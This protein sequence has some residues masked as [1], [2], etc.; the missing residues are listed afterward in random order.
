MTQRNSMQ[1]PLSHTQHHQQQHH[2]AA[3]SI[4]CKAASSNS[5]TPAAPGRGGGGGD[6]D[7]SAF[8]QSIQQQFDTRAP[9]YDSDTSY[10]APLAAALLDLLQLQ[11]GGPTWVLDLAAGTGLVGLAAAAAVGPQGRVVLV[12]VSAGMLAQAKAKYDAATAVG[13]EATTPAANAAAATSPAGI[14]A[15]KIIQGDIEDLQICL[16]PDWLGSFDAI[17]CSAATPFLRDPPAAL[18]AWRAWLKQPGGQLAFNTF[19]PPALEDFGTFRRLLAEAG[20]AE[21]PEPFEALGSVEAVTS[22]LK[23]AGYSHVQVCVC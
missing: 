5:N 12:D 20:V 6:S 11:P 22:A 2:S 15:V 7:T 3:H 1:H 19:V 8:L 16:Q 18:A 13:G 4:T 9:K 21:V 14:A 23:A 10:H 17:T